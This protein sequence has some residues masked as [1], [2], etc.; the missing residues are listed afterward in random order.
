MQL[1]VGGLASDTTEKEINGLFSGIGGVESVTVVRDIASGESRGFAMVRIPDD[2][3]G[4]A[5][6]ARL[7]GVMLGDRKIIVSRMPDTL[8][9]EMEF[10]EWLRDNG[11]EVLR[12][13]GIRPGQTLL[14]YG[15][16]PGT[17]TIPAAGITGQEGKV[18]AIDVRPR[19][20]E[21]LRERAESGGLSNI[22]ARLS[23]STSL[24][25]GLPDESVDIILVYD[26][27]HEVNDRPG[28]LEELHRVLERDGLLSV[29]PMHMGTD[30]MLEV[31]AECDLF[32]L[33]ERHSPPGHKSASEILNFSKC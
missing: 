13:V 22:E 16:G 1:Y 25:T 12:K 4:E 27:M 3:T 11:S 5:T 33:K 17:F 29:F 26:V 14:D 9:G 7:N 6:I 10:R 24:N 15:C 18:Y 21:R 30:K 2:A 32:C 23:D 20:L 8:P 19:A 28:L 31:M